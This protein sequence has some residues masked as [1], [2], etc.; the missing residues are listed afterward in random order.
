MLESSGVRGLT[1]ESTSDQVWYAVMDLALLS[2]GLAIGDAARVY[3]AAID[4]LDSMYLIA[5]RVTEEVFFD[6]LTREIALYGGFTEDEGSRL[7]EEGGE[8]AERPGVREL[9]ESDG[10]D[11]ARELGGRTGSRITVALGDPDEALGDPEPVGSPEG[12]GAGSTP[13][14]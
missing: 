10:G 4:H 13:S 8:V 9:L 5:P 3:A 6:R 11:S 12:S 1:N 2:R 7:R 14:E